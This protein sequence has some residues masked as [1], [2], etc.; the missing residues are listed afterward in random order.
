M[1]VTGFR[2]PAQ[3]EKKT[4]RRGR[5]IV[6]QRLIAATAELLAEVGPQISIRTLCERAKVNSGLVYHYFGS[7]EALLRA[8]MKHLTKETHER[9]QEKA[10]LLKGAAKLGSHEFEATEILSLLQTEERYWRALCHAVLDRSTDLYRTGI[11]TGMSAPRNYIQRLRQQSGGSLNPEQ[12]TEALATIA[13]LLGFVVF[14]PFLL[15]LIETD[16]DRP[17]ADVLQREFARIL[18]GVGEFGFIDR[19]A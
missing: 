15:A 12:I 5:A 19:R 4:P 7:K 6:E 13:L 2:M 18:G 14:E 8:G 10:A 17:S 16:S 1:S 3:A 11:E 9:V